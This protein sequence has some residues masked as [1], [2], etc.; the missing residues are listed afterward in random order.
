MSNRIYNKNGTDKTLILSP[1]S[2]FSRQSNIGT[3]WSEIRIGF[4][5]TLVSGS[6]DNTP[7]IEENVSYTTPLDLFTVGL[8][9][10][11]GSKHGDVGSNFIGVSTISDGGIGT[12]ARNDM[13][14]NVF[15][16]FGKVLVSYVGSTQTLGTNTSIAGANFTFPSANSAVYNGIACIKIEILNRGLSNQQFRLSLSNEGT[17]TADYTNTDLKTAVLNRSY[18][19]YAYNLNWNDGSSARELPTCFYIWNPLYN[20]EIRIS[21]MRIDKFA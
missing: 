15:Q 17:N 5:Y 3:D 12:R 14:G 8:I 18:S 7:G 13:I 11:T 6:S 1:R 10:V 19:T 9:S 4:Y 16:A 20:N 21:T 2:G